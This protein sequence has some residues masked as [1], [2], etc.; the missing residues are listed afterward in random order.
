M[1]QT[2]KLLSRCV[3]LQKKVYT[4]VCLKSAWYF[5]VMTTDL[6]SA[7]PVEYCGVD[8]L[9]NSCLKLY[10]CDVLSVKEHDSRLG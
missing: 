1:K 6:P 4:S 7:L 2:E 9:F 5:T 8:P 10:I 3:S